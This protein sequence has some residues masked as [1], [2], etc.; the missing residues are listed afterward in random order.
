M[1]KT[2][3]SEVFR[4]YSLHVPCSSSLLVV[5][6]CSA[7]TTD[8]QS[9]HTS[10]L[11]EYRSSSTTLVDP[12]SAQVGILPSSNYVFPRETKGSGLSRQIIEQYNSFDVLSHSDTSNLSPTL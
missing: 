2:I 3:E 7:V 1:K 6:R 5:V 11:S 8:P 4:G 12:H 10:V 9:S